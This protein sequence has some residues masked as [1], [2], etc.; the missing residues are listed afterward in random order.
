MKP[1]VLIVDDERAIRLSL[2]GLLEKEGYDVVGAATYDEAIAAIGKGVDLVLTDL[3]LGKGSGGLEILR[4]A[5]QQCEST[6]VVMITAHGSEKVA[7]SAM[8]AGADDYV[9]KPFD[10]DEI[11]LL[12]GRLLRQHQA[13]REHELLLAR[14]ERDYGSGSIVGGGAAMRAV[15]DA[16]AR[17]ADTDLSVLVRGESGT[18]KELVAQALHQR[19]RRARRPFV[20]V[21]AAAI[22]RELVESELFGHEKGSFTG[23]SARRIGRFEAADGGTIFLDEIGDMPLET[24]A[25]VLRVLEERK[26]ERVGGDRPIDV[27][28]RVVAAT[29]RDLEVEVK[30]GRFRQDLYYRLRVVEIVLPP[31][32]ERIED[33]PA[34]VERFLEKVALRLG[35]SKRSLSASALAALGRHSF[36]GN[37]RELRNV[38]EHAV[39]LAEGEH[40]EAADLRLDGAGGGAH[41]A[42]RQS[43]IFADAKK[44][45]VEE[46][47]RRFLRQALREHGGNVSA[48]AEAI[49]MVRQSLQQKL[50]ELRI[51][52]GEIGDDDGEG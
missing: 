27:D 38:I 8:K 14:V 4:A 30:R 36:P 10:N 28:V 3:A 11:R 44:Q 2:C 34:L 39:V 47:E 13:A 26:I 32:R 22:H 6:P 18:G 31:L 50:R 49:G 52:A 5:K 7:V 43:G 19:G 1:C 9:P 29:H 42:I 23:A 37:V 41:T 33:V 25:K 48:T 17:V 40:I 16:I 15:M 21:N 46:F 12:V 24:Q 35:R 51:R 20:A 45:V